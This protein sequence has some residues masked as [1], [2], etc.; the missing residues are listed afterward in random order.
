M[1]LFSSVTGSLR[2]SKKL[3]KLQKQIAPRGRN[4]GDLVSDLKQSVTSGTSRKDQALE[5]FLDLCES[6]EGV[7]KVMRQYK[8]NRE[9][10]KQIYARLTT[11]GLGQYVKGH[12]VALSTI[13]YYEPLLFVVESER[14]GE[15]WMNV[16]GD[17]FSYW[18]GTIPQSGL[19]DKLR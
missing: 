11:A 8:L 1:S 18:R 17:L 15:D 3:Q 4:V 10:L 7:S 12:H 2:K 13:A 19:I 16:M 6:D 5:E 9:D 14:R